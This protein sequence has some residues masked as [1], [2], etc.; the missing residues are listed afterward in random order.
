MKVGR[1]AWWLALLTCSVPAA[2]QAQGFGLNEIGTCAVGRGQAVTG[3][4]CADPSVIYW[5]PA[6]A[7]MLD[8]WS[9]YLGAAAIAVNGEFTADTTGRIDKGDVP[10]R[11]V[12]HLFVN[13][14]PKS[15]QWAA[16]LGVYIP[17]GLTSQWNS[18]FPGRFTAQ[19]ASIASVYIQPN[20]AWQFAKGWSVGGGPVL[21]Y[22]QVQ[23]RQSLDLSTQSPAP[24]ITFGMLGVPA[25]T[26]FGR[27]RLEGSATA[28]GFNVGVH[29]RLGPDWQVGARYLHQ[30]DFKYDDADATFTQ[31]L[32]GLTLAAN[33]PLGLPANTP[34]DALL[35]PEFAPG[36]PL[37][38]Q[39]VA[40]EIKHPRQFEAG[41]G[42]TG[43]TNTTLSADFVLINYKAFNQLPVKFAGSA[44]SFTLLEDYNNSW[45][46]RFG[47]EHAFAAG[48]RGRAGF[49]YVKTPAPDVTVTPLLPDQDRR[50]FMLGLGV[51]LSGRYTLDAGYLHVDTSGRR[52]RIV[53]RTSESETA[54]QL[55][56]GFYSLNA[57]VWSL[58]VKANF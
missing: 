52:G 40:T 2:T 9:A 10:I 18:D 30:L 54:A 36:G 46:V 26:E 15:K 12:P 20:L 22:S 17:Y 5:N 41:L 28:W 19:R 49:T 21:G 43:F 53:E 47:A 7:T 38:A 57:N 50:N 48:F 51:P 45:S 55:N 37:S 3:A 39:K 29:G 34:V 56:S 13:Y 32:T 4:P 35:T 11:F 8:G 27:A 1:V 25:Q 23:L 42:Y 24:G 14:T 44:P 6:A 31:V 16:G 33:N 58:S